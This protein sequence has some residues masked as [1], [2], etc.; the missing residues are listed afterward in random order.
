MVKS[1]EPNAPRNG[2]SPALRVARCHERTR[3]NQELTFTGSCQINLVNRIALAVVLLPMVV[4]KLS[5]DVMGLPQQRNK[6]K[7]VGV[8][9]GIDQ[10]E[11]QPSIEH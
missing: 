2:P 9:N 5:N 4:M 10:R 7:R 3:T 6:S 8:I 1:P 11:T